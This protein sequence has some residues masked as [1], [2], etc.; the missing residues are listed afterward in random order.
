MTM[1]LYESDSWATIQN[2]CLLK[3]DWLAL[4][5]QPN[6]EKIE[7]DDSFLKRESSGLWFTSE[8]MNVH[9]SINKPKVVFSCSSCLTVDQKYGFYSTPQGIFPVDIDKR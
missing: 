5:L 4:P 6:T 7:Y 1:L 9:N 3:E 2:K 8:E